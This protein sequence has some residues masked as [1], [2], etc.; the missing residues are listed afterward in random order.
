MYL[1]YVSHLGIL[2]ADAVYVPFLPLYPHDN[3][4]LLAILAP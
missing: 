3:S 2:S 4:C 1:I